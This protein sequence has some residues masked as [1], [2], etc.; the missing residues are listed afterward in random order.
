[1]KKALVIYALSEAGLNRKQLSRVADYISTQCDEWETI[2]HLRGM[3]E[4]PNAYY[5]VLVKEIRNV[6][7]PSGYKSRL[8]RQ[9]HL[10]RI[11]KQTRMNS[12][13]CFGGEFVSPLTFMSKDHSRA[14]YSLLNGITRYCQDAD[15]LACR[16]VTMH[17]SWIT[18]NDMITMEIIVEESGM[19]QEE[20]ERHLKVL[21]KIEK[22]MFE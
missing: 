18:Y 16:L 15:V 4:D 8:R 11:G 13:Y 19:P 14:R 6:W 2:D 10:Q 17:K 9:L 7:H 3:I 21:R 5:D 12:R 20:V 1:M 22:L